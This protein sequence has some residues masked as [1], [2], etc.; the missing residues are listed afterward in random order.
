M[1][2]RHTYFV[3]VARKFDSMVYTYKTQKSGNLLT[4]VQYNTN[5]LNF[6]RR[7]RGT[8]VISQS[9]H[10]NATLFFCRK[11]T[12]VIADDVCDRNDLSPTLSHR[13]HQVMLRRGFMNG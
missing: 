5:V 3:A 1:L 2:C 10:Y 4:A 9:A 6:F 7:L 13:A 11:A 12:L 8:Q